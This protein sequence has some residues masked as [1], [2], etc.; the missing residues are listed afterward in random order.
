MTNVGQIELPRQLSRV[1][2]ILSETLGFGIGLGVAWNVFLMEW[3]AP[4]KMEASHII[5]LFGYVLVVLS[6]SFQISGLLQ[7]H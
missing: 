5:V 3:L 1:R 2:T 7:H 6:I 4:K